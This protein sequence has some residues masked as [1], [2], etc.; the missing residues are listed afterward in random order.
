MSKE[1][2]GEMVATAPVSTVQ[3]KKQADAITNRR[4]LY[5][6]GV[7]LLPFPL[8]DIAALLGIQVVMIRDIAKVYDVDFMEQPVQSLITTLVGDLGA[9]G[10]VSGVKTIPVIGSYIGGFTLS[11]T[12]AA[13]TYALGKVFTQHFDQGGTLLTF[14]PVKSRKYFQQAFEE[15]KLYVEDLAESDQ[16]AQEKSGWRKFFNIK[17]K[18]LLA[19]KESSDTTEELAELRK[20]NEEIK[21][22]IQQLQQSV[23]ALKK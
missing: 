8:I 13:A 7:G 20:K 3:L 23:E 11:I 19:K 16:A 12:G 15:G 21:V 6:A 5:A 14:D 9:V 1:K 4:T 2:Q 17:D 10:V 22:M 18:T